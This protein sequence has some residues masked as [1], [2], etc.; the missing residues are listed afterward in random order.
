[1][2]VGGGVIGESAMDATQCNSLQFK[3]SNLVF[4]EELDRFVSCL[5]Y[6]FF[7]FIFFF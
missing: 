2:C 7:A 6:L 4:E 3:E 1:M 5:I